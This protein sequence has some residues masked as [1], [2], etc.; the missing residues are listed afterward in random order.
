L[1]RGCRWLLP[2]G[3]WLLLAACAGSPPV[4]LESPAAPQPGQ[5]EVQAD[6]A[7]HQGR[8]VRWGGEIIGVRNDPTST[9]VEIYGRPL[10][11]NAEPAASGGEGV[12]FLARVDGFLDP[13]EYQAGKRMTVRGTVAGV[14]TRPVGDY[15]YRYP[16]VAVDTHHLW[17]P[18]A[19]TEPAH[20]RD[21]YYYDPWWP[22]GPWGPY[23]YGPYWW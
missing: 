3:L 11:D 10:Q 17:P 12:R 15:P 19:E 4:G 9:D 22:W 6:P 16:V 7:A 1:S 18:Y 23:R 20:W 13:A 14:E 5:R 2:T 8:A 21:P